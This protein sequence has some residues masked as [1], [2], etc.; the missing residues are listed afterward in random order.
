MKFFSNLF[1]KV[2]AVC[3]A[4]AFCQAPLVMQQYS[5]RLAGHLEE[6]ALAYQQIVNLAKSNQ[7]SIQEYLDVFVQNSDPVLSSQGKFLQDVCMRHF[8]L[9]DAWQSLQDATPLTKPFIFFKHI[10]FEILRSTLSSF[11]P[12]FAFN[13][14]TVIYGLIGLL[15]GTLCYYFICKMFSSLFSKFKRKEKPVETTPQKP[16]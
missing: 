2:F 14:E 7:K 4:I 1:D 16:L 9:V 13:V 11:S 6:N 8:S 5:L 3:G 15:F 12:G 10:D